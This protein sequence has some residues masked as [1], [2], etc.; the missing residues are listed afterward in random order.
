MADGEWIAVLY[1]AEQ[2]T[3]DQFQALIGIFTGESGGPWA[4]ITQFFKGSEYVVV[5]RMPLQ[6]TI[7]ARSRSVKVSSQLLL[8][9]EAIRGADQEGVAVIYNLR[10]VIH[11]PQ[12]VMARSNHKVDAEGLAWEIGGKHG[13]YSRIGWSG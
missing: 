7:N 11:G 5:R 9:V 6:I 1:I 3:D 12:H 2:A 4:T 13:L 8:E 10:N